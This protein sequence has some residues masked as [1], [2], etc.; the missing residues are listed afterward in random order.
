MPQQ[1]SQLEHRKADSLL[2]QRAAPQQMSQV[3][4]CR[5]EH[6]CGYVQPVQD[7][8]SCEPKSRGCVLALGLAPSEFRSSA[9]NPHCRVSVLEATLEQARADST[10]PVL[11]ASASP[12]RRW[13]G[14]GRLCTPALCSS[15]GCCVYLAHRPRLVLRGGRLRRAGLGC[16]AA[17]VRDRRRP[18]P[19]LANWL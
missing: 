7:T 17:G 6:Q 19:H 4:S 13:H 8:P 18:A 15:S 14:A 9:R 10:P 1:L 11:A 3:C 16:S 5:L 12:H 2:Q